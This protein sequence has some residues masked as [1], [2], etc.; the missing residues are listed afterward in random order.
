MKITIGLGLREVSY[1]LLIQ[2][3]QPETTI[4]TALPQQA[5]S[6]RPKLRTTIF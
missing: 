5:S 3:I 1:T 6:L 4:S 2:F